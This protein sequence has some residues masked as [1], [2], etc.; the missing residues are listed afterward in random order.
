MQD[1][2]CMSSEFKEDLRILVSKKSFSFKIKFDN[3]HFT[4]ATKH[5]I[6]VLAENYNIF[7]NSAVIKTMILFQI[8]TVMAFAMISI[9]CS[10][11]Q[12]SLG[13][14]GTGFAS[15]RPN[16]ESPYDEY[17]FDIFESNVNQRYCT[18]DNIYTFVMP[19][20]CYLSF[21]LKWS[22]AL[23]S[24]FLVHFMGSHQRPPADHGV[25]WIRAP[26]AG[27]Y[28]NVHRPVL[29]KPGSCRK[30]NSQTS[31][32]IGLYRKFTLNILFVR[33][34]KAQLIQV[35]QT[36]LKLFTN[37]LPLLI[38]YFFSIFSNWSRKYIPSTNVQVLR[39]NL[40]VLKKWL[41]TLH[42]KWI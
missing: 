5:A 37:F 26:P 25:H 35:N 36:S 39:N 11:I 12:F 24:N 34:M 16:L 1:K 22:L 13:V 27:G 38:T 20:F 32:W 28:F 3:S 6:L 15:R 21:S 2:R 29:R 41:Q 18:A 10:V 40:I 23:K 8:T 33:I 19:S 9:F 7:K 4:M 14:V 42:R 31:S 17:V 30:F